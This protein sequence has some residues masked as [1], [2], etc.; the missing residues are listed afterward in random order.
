VKSAMRAHRP[1]LSYCI[2]NVACWQILLQ[3]S[4]IRRARY[5]LG[6]LTP[7]IAPALFGGR[8]SDVLDRPLTTTQHSQRP[9]EAV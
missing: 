1:K 5:L 7:F 8:G 4:S 2:A 3:K 6:V 9:P